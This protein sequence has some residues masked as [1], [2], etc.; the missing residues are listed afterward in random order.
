MD[1]LNTILKISTFLVNNFRKK[2][3]SQLDVSA[4]IKSVQEVDVEI[5][6]ISNIVS[7]LESLSQEQQEMEQ[8]A[9]SSKLN[10]STLEQ[11]RGEAENVLEFR[12][13]EEVQKQW[14]VLTKKLKQASKEKTPK[15]EMKPVKH[16]TD[17]L[18][19][20]TQAL[21]KAPKD[22][23]EEAKLAGICESDFEKALAKDAHSILQGR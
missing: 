16:L 14:K 22:K 13:D 4:M 15:P 21:S 11:K 10:G 18:S 6:G 12:T 19:H 20:L 1:N 9:V 5:A 3:G 8:E 23:E 2:F 17:F 7:R